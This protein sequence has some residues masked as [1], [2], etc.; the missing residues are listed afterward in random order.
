MN[1]S[2]LFDQRL[3]LQIKVE[4]VGSRGGSGL[5][6]SGRARASYFELGLFGA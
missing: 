1:D 4:Y 6:F 2:V 5:I 3:I